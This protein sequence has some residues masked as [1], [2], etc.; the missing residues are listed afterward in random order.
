MLIYTYFIN[1]EI[2]SGWTNQLLIY[3]TVNVCFTRSFVNLCSLS[4]Q[5]ISSIELW[6][7]IFLAGNYCS[8]NFFTNGIHLQ[9]DDTYGSWYSANGFQIFWAY[10][11]ELSFFL[12][13]VC[14]KGLHTLIDVWLI[15]YLFGWSIIVM[16][17]TLFFLFS[18]EFLHLVH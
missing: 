6:A 4:Q 12:Y 9:C 16:K 13:G 8:N 10:C 2:S 3:S 17:F 15:S 1:I 14:W 7:N 11:S 18:K 5:I